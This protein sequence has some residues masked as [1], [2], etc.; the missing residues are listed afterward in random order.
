MGYL[1]FKFNNLS[2]SERD[3]LNVIQVDEVLTVGGVAGEYS[4]IQSA[5]NYA[6]AIANKGK[7]ID[8]HI[9]SGLYNEAIN[10]PDCG[11]DGLTAMTG[12]MAEAGTLR[13][14]GVGYVKIYQGD[15]ATT[16]TIKVLRPCVQLHN[17]VVTSLS[18]QPAIY[19]ICDN[20]TG[21]GGDINNGFAA[22]LIINNCNVRGGGPDDTAVASSCGISLVG[23]LKTVITNCLI[24]DFVN[25]I[26]IIGS[27]VNYALYNTIENCDFDGNTNDISVNSVQYSYIK[28]CNFLDA[29]A[30]RY[31]ATNT[32][33]NPCTG[34]KI[35]GGTVAAVNLTKFTGVAGWSAIGIIGAANPASLFDLDLSS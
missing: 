31:L 9:R 7:N 12:S 4:T 24:E 17:L 28:N 20:N 32:G 29:S 6:T 1:D 26:D 10:I 23:A 21:A 25:G 11:S 18:A 15:T 5:V 34:C 22:G 3:I 27:N 2:P 14:I 33:L 8:I 16:P 13:L 19:G 35:I 30:T